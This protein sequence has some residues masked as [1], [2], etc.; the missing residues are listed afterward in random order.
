MKINNIV[1]SGIVIVILLIILILWFAVFREP[2]VTELGNL[3]YEELCKGNGDQ[4]MEMEP[5]SKGKMTSD[6]MCF[7]CMIAD[8]HFCSVDEYIGYIKSLPSF[9]R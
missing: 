4:W 5:T 6:T 3:T 8:N 1:I 2:R 7:G 9:V